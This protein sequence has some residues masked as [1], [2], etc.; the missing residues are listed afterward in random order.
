MSKKTK[1]DYSDFISLEEYQ[2]HNKKAKRHGKF[3]YEVKRKFKDERLLL[4]HNKV[5]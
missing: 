5:C 1:L 4:I 3:R 2:E